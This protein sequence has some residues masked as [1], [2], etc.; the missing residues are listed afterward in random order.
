MNE[1]G[2]YQ[3]EGAFV[4]VKKY[5]T[6]MD[7]NVGSLSVFFSYTIVRQKLN[8]VVFYFYIIIIQLFTSLIFYFQKVS[9]LFFSRQKARFV[10]HWGPCCCSFAACCNCD[11]RSLLPKISP[12]GQ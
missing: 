12:N 10:R 2:N 5:K 3:K 1:L 9:P 8:F 11:D 6:K 7:I 4:V